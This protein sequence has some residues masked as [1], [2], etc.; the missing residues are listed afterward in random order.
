[1]YFGLRDCLQTDIRP[2]WDN[3]VDI[4]VENCVK[5]LLSIIFS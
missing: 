2:K 1:M 5:P 3:V 4:P